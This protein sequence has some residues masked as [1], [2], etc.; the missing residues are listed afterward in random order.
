MITDEEYGRLL[1]AMVN[2]ERAIG[3]LEGKVDRAIEAS[4]S[5]FEEAQR[6]NAAL[7]HHLGTGD[8]ADDETPTSPQTPNS[9]APHRRSQVSVHEDDSGRPSAMIQAFTQTASA[10]A[11]PL[12]YRGPALVA[13]V[14]AV[15][16]AVAMTHGVHLPF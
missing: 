1:A 16:A 6:C 4:H 7:A 3:R 2:V 5:A 11:G 9:I 8:F 10:K 12:S 14:L 13:V 15:I